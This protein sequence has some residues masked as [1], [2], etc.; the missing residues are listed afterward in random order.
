ML[1]KNLFMIKKLKK[2][3]KK[4]MMIIENKEQIMWLKK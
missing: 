3:N 4:F 1:K 2:Y